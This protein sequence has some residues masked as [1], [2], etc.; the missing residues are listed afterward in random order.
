M[1]KVR[2][3]RVLLVLLLV[4]ALLAGQNVA[5]VQVTPDA[6][7][8]NPGSKQALFAAAFDAKGNLIPTARFSFS[9]TDTTIVRANPDGAVVGLAPG[10]AIV[11][12]RSGRKSFNVAVVVNAPDGGEP[13]SLADSA[14]RPAAPVDSGPAPTLLTI[15]PAT[16]YLL[17]SE[18]RVLAAQAFR[19]DGTP[20]P[21]LR[22]VWKSLSPAVATVDTAGVVVGLKPGQATIQ[23]TVGTLSATAPVEVKAAAFAPQPARVVLAPMD[24]DTIRLAVPDQGDRELRSG[25]SWRIADTAVARVGPTGIVQGL[26][27]GRTQ[28]VVSGY[29]QE[30]R[31]PV[32]VHR[33]IERV[34]V[35][36]A[37]A[38][39]PIRL[40]VS[41]TTRLTV[42]A[43]AADS[44]VVAGVDFDWEVGDTSV[45]GFDAASGT[46]IARSTGTTSLTLRAPGFA[47]LVWVV[48]VLPGGIVLHRHFLT[49]AP[50]AHDSLAVHYVDTKG[51]A[52]GDAT[53]LLWI[54]TDSNVVA[55]AGNGRVVAHRPGT[56]KLMVETR[57]GAADSAIVFVVAPLVVASNREG[58]FALYQVS[59]KRTLLHLAGDTAD[60]VQPA[61][62]PD[63]SW[64]AYSSNRGG[65]FDL[66]LARPDGSGAVALA[67][68]VGLDGEPAW[69]P[70]G[71]SLVFASSRTGSPQIF[72][73]NIDGTG[74]R[75]LTFTGGGNR[76]PAVSPDGRTI[77]FLSGRDGNTEVYRMRADGTGQTNV[78]RTPGREAA[79]RFFPDGSLAYASQSRGTRPY[80]LVRLPVDGSPAEPLFTSADPIIDFAVARDGRQLAVIT[81][82]TRGTQVDYAF[83]LAPV[84]DGAP[85]QVPLRPGEQVVSPNY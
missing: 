38:S 13:V 6:V 40:P 46:L 1:L 11:R 67:P 83:Y 69:M 74:L 34:V 10:R 80:R 37:P 12:V 65:N 75:Q 30:H 16:I 60:M 52:A 9:S 56:V 85:V 22:V 26:S 25:L 47:P 42:Q 33:P 19:P 18:S 21:R 84:G 31:I 23:A 2:S 51:A 55:L 54:T 32:S 72:R 76:A 82:R 7:T 57:W 3:L 27:P 78:S 73:I 14:S 49:L 79:V 48:E 41:G 35:A 29:F 4:P 39:G 81:G 71:R 62:S 15:N 64:L 20:A 36:P 43:Q 66:Y 5:E 28:L 68:A 70:D 24:L 63:R 50:D 77:A 58:R 8:L 53:G 44:S 17:P 45:A 59:G 61:L